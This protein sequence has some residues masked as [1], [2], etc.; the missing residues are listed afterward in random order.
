[1]TKNKKDNGKQQIPSPTTPIDELDA[2]KFAA[3]DS[4]MKFRLQAMECLNV[5]KENEIL[6]RKVFDLQTSINIRVLDDQLLA[7]RDQVEKLNQKYNTVKKEIAAKY[8]FDDPNRVAID[9]EKG[10]IREVPVPI[11][12]GG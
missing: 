7:E 11:P 3:S 10:T 2:Y 12:P 8:G 4:D 5:K 9:E 1:M 6:K